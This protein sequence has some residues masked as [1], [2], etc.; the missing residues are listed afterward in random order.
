M[1]FLI[2]SRYLVSMGAIFFSVLWI[3]PSVAYGNSI[4]VDFT[5]QGSF[6]AVGWQQGVLTV[7]GSNTL[8]F[9][10]YNG[11]GVVGETD[12]AV[13][14][15]ESVFFLFSSPANYVR[16]FNG[17]IGNV[18]GIKYR[19]AKIQVFGVDGVL[20]GTAVGVEPTPWIVISELFDNAPI[21]SFSVLATEDLYRF[22][23][24]EFALSV[25]EPK[26]AS[27]LIGGMCCLFIALRSVRCRQ[28][29][30]A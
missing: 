1:R 22:S 27:M 17:A 26:A 8:N 2:A 5:N 7:T 13:D 10:Q 29:E 9:L 18:N 25:P 14:P 12:S 21:T 30:S 11:V 28:S 20:I 4:T 24:I 16:L 6:Q 23:A 19:T 3:Q 15:G